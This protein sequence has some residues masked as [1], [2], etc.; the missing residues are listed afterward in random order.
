MDAWEH[1]TNGK[2][3][4]LHQSSQHC[5]GMK[6]Q[7]NDIDNVDNIAE[8]NIVTNWFLKRPRLIT[9]LPLITFL[10]YKMILLD[11]FYVSYNSFTSSVF[12][13]IFSKLGNYYHKSI[14]E[15]FH[16]PN[17]IVHAIL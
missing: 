12:L 6:V 9:V 11:I 14:L 1:Q 2:L 3:F 17:K 8:S 4:R 16:H 5:F 7:E 13:G 15:H 10:L